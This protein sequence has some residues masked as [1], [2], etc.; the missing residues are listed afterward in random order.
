MQIMK[1]IGENIV[2]VTVIQ[3]GLFAALSAI[4]QLLGW[5]AASKWCGTLSS[6]DLGRIVR[7][8][9]AQTDA[10]K[11]DQ[12]MAKVE[13]AVG[14]DALLK[15]T[16]GVLFVTLLLSGCSLEAARTKRVNAPPSAPLAYYALPP[17]RTVTQ[18]EAWDSFHVWGDWTAGV[19]AGVGATATGLVAASDAGDFRN[20]VTGVAI[21]AGVV[22]GVTLILADQSASKWAERC[23]Q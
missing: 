9:A 22:S 20:A 12:K 18:C 10:A 2:L 6:L 1:W 3:Q 4:F 13:Q 8:F 11:L 5:V 23:G 7:Y 16:L 14:K 15:N 19:G 21:G 17:T